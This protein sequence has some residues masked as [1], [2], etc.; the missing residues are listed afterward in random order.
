MEGAESEVMGSVWGGC[1][2]VGCMSS[3]MDFIG[4]SG[5]YFSCVL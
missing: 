4:M 1:M 5:M 2:H 3:Y